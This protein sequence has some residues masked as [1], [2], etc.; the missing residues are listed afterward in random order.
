MKFYRVDRRLYNEGNKI[1]P[2]TEY[3]QA[4]NNKDKKKLE[5]K[6]DE[7]KSMKKARKEYLFSL[8]L[9]IML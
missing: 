4:L 9:Y 8:L 3:S 1:L 5:K 7:T 6:L 2:D